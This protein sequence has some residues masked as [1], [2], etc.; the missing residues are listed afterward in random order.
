MTDGP[1]P[2]LAALQFVPHDRGPDAT[3]ADLEMGATGKRTG[4]AERRDLA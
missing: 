3:L 1:Q 2:A 4:L